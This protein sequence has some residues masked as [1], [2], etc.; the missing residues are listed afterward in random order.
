MQA[1]TILK[2]KH[3]LYQTQADKFDNLWVHN[4]NN[5]LAGAW[6]KN[7][8]YK[9]NSFDIQ[10]IANLYKASWGLN[11]LQDLDNKKER[12]S[13]NLWLS[14][15]GKILEIEFVTAVNTTLVIDELEILEDLLKDNI[16]FTIT[17]LDDKEAN[18]ATMGFALPF[19]SIIYQPE[20]SDKSTRGAKITNAAISP[21]PLP[22]NLNKD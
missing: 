20:E 4:T 11:R 7:N 1:D 10:S 3:T 13:I 19:S 12:L 16:S 15:E 8:R 17:W 5:I 22:D 6:P 2:A 18:Y 9:I 21:P 14:P